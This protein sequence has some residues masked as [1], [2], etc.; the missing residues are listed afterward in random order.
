[1]VVSWAA[2]MSGMSN[3]HEAR[4]ELWEVDLQCPRCGAMNRPGAT[5]IP[6]DATGLAVCM[7]CANAWT[8]C[9]AEINGSSSVMLEDS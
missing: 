9:L 3:W 5:L 6:L 8:P 4:R 1:M 7:V 2:P